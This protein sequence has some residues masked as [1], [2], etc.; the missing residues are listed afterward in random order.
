MYE[1]RRTLN[2]RICFGKVSRLDSN[3]GKYTLIDSRKNLNPEKCQFTLVVS[4][5][6]DIEI[7]AC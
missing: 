6:V 3:G 4:L 1:L 5:I 7:E 2:G